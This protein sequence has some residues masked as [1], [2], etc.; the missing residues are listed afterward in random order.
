[1]AVSLVNAQKHYLTNQ[2]VYDLYQM[3]PAAAAFQKNCITANGF[4]QKQWFGTDKAPT[5]QI[6]SLQLPVQ[7]GLGSGTYIYN[8]RNGVIKEMGINQAF[9][10]ELLLQENRR[11]FSTLTFG[12]SFLLEQSSIDQT[13]FH[14][15]NGTLADD[16]IINDGVENGIGFNASAGLLYKINTTHAGISITSLMPNNNPM[17][18]SSSQETEH[19]MDIHVHVG[20]S[21]AV[22]GRDVVLEPLVKY[23]RNILKDSQVDLNMKLYMPTPN[24]DIAIWGLLAYRHTLDQGIGKSNGMAVT[25]GIA[26]GNFSFGIEY[27]LGLTTAQIDYGSYYQ[28]ILSWRLCRDKS[29]SA[30]SC[31]KIKRRGYNFNFLGY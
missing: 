10:Y 30:L 24:E 29:K 17:Y 26:Y 15:G 1:M 25:G 9:S 12:I 4:Y 20:G 3:N 18:N 21:Y 22:P 19:V 8:D 23:R 5:T 7:G 16:P 11:R 31:P 28:L 14:D 27:Q 6:L 2:Y 13:E